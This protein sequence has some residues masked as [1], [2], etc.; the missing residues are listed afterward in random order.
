MRFRHLLVCETNEVTFLFVRKFSLMINARADSKHSIGGRL[1]GRLNGAD[2]LEKN[3][4]RKS[5]A[6]F[7]LFVRFMEM[8][9]CAHDGDN[10][11]EET[12]TS[13]D[14]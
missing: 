9:I 6:L 1:I 14:L 13:G 3:A 7:Y 5:A 8:I 11:P 10:S 2:T 4:M 12:A